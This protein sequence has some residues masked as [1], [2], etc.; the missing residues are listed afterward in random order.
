MSESNKVTVTGVVEQVGHKDGRVSAYKVQGRWLNISNR[1][2]PDLPVPT[3]GDRIRAVCAPWGSQNA[4]YID[5]L[6][7][8]GNANP[9]SSPPSTNGAHPVSSAPPMEVASTPRALSIQEV[10]LR[11]LEAMSPFL[12]SR[13]D[14]STMQDFFAKAEEVERWVLDA[15]PHT[16]PEAIQEEIPF[17]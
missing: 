9:P 14:T 6:W 10:R 12:A 8:E 3:V 7:I 5:D 2:R 15:E 4:L 17:S 11:V 1:S 13:A 16:F